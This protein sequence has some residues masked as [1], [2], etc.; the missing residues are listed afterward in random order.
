MVQLGAGTLG[1]FWNIEM[2]AI[3]KI[4]AHAKEWAAISGFE[5][6]DPSLDGQVAFAQH[7]YHQLDSAQKKIKFLS[8]NLVWVIFNVVTTLYSCVGQMNFDFQILKNKN[9]YVDTFSL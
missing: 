8:A 5:T 4:Y 1:W 6:Q 9:R 3:S 7:T 2:A